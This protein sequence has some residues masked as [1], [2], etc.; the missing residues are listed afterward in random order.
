[1]LVVADIATD[2]HYKLLLRL[3][4][5]INKSMLVV[6]DIATDKLK[7]AVNTNTARIYP[8]KWC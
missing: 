5:L 2:K 8:L 7:Q 3:L 1:M 6:A 4:T